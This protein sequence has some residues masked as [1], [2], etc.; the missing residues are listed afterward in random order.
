MPLTTF[1][2]FNEKS[3]DWSEFD[4]EGDARSQAAR[5]S[6]RQPTWAA[7]TRA[8]KRRMTGRETVQHKL[9]NR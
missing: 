1:S 7:L 2:N 6:P 8:P 9:S 3:I 4:E 5:P